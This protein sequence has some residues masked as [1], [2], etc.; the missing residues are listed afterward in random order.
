M[1]YAQV[2]GGKRGPGIDPEDLLLELVG[3]RAQDHERR[4]IRA[5]P[6]IACVSKLAQL[7]LCGGHE[8]HT[9]HAQCRRRLRYAGVCACMC[10]CVCMHSSVI[11][12][13]LA[14]DGA[15][16]MQVGVYVCV[17]VCTAVSYL[18]R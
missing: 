17:C 4:H 2:R 9:R 8:R 16:V 6:V 7:A 14:V 18:P 12:A 15:F 1:Q 3:Q 11:L 13:T 10:V 5:A